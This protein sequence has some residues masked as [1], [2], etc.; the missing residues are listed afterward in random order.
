MES[1]FLEAAQI[2]LL[3][4]PGNDN[5][6]GKIKIPAVCLLYFNI[7]EVNTRRQNLLLI[8]DNDHSKLRILVYSHQGNLRI[9]ALVVTATIRHPCP[10]A[11]ARITIFLLQPRY[12]DGSTSHQ[13]SLIPTYSTYFYSSSPSSPLLPPPLSPL[14]IPLLFLLNALYT[15]V[16]SFFSL[17]AFI[18][19]TINLTR[20]RQQQ[21]PQGGRRSNASSGCC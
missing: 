13:L 14:L 5:D 10:G 8:F 12:R 21:S 9:W 3:Q 6:A 17:S 16:I 20:Q 11:S 1:A 15:L 4:E 7:V 2:A 18:P 19:E